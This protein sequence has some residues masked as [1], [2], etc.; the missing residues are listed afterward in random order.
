[1]K[2]FL[3]L[4][5]L[6]LSSCAHRKDA[7][8]GDFVYPDDFYRGFVYNRTT[9]QL[10]EQSSF[11]VVIG[12]NGWLYE[13]HDLNATYR[14]SFFSEP[15]LIQKSL[16]F[17]GLKRY[18][19]SKG[20]KIIFFIPPTTPSIHPEYLP[21]GIKISDTTSVDQLYRYLKENSI[22][23]VVYPKEAFL[24]EKWNYTLYYKTDSHWTEIGAFFGVRELMAHASKWFP[25][26]QH[27]FEDYRVVNRR[28]FGGPLT[29]ALN[30]EHFYIE[31][32]INL[33]PQFKLK[34]QS[35]PLKV[36]IIHDS[37]YYA[38]QKFI[39]ENFEVITKHLKRDGI[40]GASQDET[41]N[42]V[43]AQMDATKP[44]IVILWLCERGYEMLIGKNK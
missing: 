13:G 44:D 3:I 5:L 1:M 12:K 9:H 4:I 16:F 29:K 33:E 28:S 32:Q 34:V 14:R 6:A 7:F 20:I 27:N 42:N 30:I 26:V 38:A 22:I 21:K 19:D 37:Y 39:R 36:L 43:I 18:A 10:N 8:I 35:S 15:E 17:K 41:I 23:D 40:R 11:E 31:D 2:I 25:I 24:K